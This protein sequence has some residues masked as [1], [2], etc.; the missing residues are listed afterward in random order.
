[1]SR[2]LP[3]GDPAQLGPFRLSARLSE[4]AAG[5]VF[6]GVDGEGRRASVAVLNRGAAEDAAARDRFRAAI[7]AAVPGAGGAGRFGGGGRG[8]APVVAAQPDGPAPWVATAYEAGGPGAERFL[9]PVVLGGSR[10]WGRRRGPQFQPHWLGSSEAALARPR[11]EP[12]VGPA[13]AP[14]RPPE[15]SLVAAVLALA[16]AL[17]V[18][19]VL[20]AVLF[21]CQ[22]RPKDPPPEPPEP[23]PS[24]TASVPPPSQPQPG[25]PPP[26]SPPPSGVPTPSPSGSG[27][28]GDGGPL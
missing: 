27:G 12:V 21:S 6:L 15:R 25:N 18:L 8:G 22:P 11:D 16:A 14:E 1:M 5:I 4:S 20:M 28:G 24:V 26:G 23:T 10:R 17:V 7:N 3:P 19:V 13:A 2:P 9:E